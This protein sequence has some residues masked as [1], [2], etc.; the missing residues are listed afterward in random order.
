[1]YASTRELASLVDNLSFIALSFSP[2]KYLFVPSFSPYFALSL[3]ANKL[4]SKVSFADFNESDIIP[5]PE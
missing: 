4:W 3:S 5:P 2:R 1:M